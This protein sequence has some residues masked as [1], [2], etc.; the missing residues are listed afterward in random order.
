MLRHL[1]AALSHV[2][3]VWSQDIFID[4]QDRNNLIQV[5]IKIFMGGLHFFGTF[6]GHLSIISMFFI[7]VSF[8][9]AIVLF[10]SHLI[11]SFGERSEA[12]LR[13]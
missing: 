9:L 2:L 12:K 10:R 8:R 3:P 7:F 13:R 1:S 5:Y 6:F 11:K 4:S